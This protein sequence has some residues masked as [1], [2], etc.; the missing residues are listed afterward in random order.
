[1]IDLFYKLKKWDSERLTLDVV[2]YIFFGLLFVGFIIL[3]VEMMYPDI[4]K[5]G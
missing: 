1:M 5:E 2:L 4:N 3:M